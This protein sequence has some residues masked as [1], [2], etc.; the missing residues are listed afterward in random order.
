M[1]LNDFFLSLLEAAYVRAHTF[2]Q[3][4]NAAQ[5]FSSIFFIAGELKC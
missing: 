1:I 5:A 2:V 3:W 4:Y